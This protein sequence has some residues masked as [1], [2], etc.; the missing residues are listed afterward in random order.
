MDG[1][2]RRDQAFYAG[3][4]ASARWYCAEVLPGLTGVRKQVERSSLALMDLP[5]EAF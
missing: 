4:V 2:G 1:A 5:D 3:K